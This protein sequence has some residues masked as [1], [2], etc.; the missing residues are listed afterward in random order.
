[1]CKKNCFHDTELIVKIVKYYFICLL[2]GVEIQIVLNKDM[3]T[4]MLP[5]KA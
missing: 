1:M 5:L 4:S 2:S 3:A